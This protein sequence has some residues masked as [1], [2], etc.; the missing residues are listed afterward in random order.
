M[1]GWLA[2]HLFL[3][4]TACLPVPILWA[5]Q[6]SDPFKIESQPANGIKTLFA[7]SPS[8][9]ASPPQGLSSQPN[10]ALHPSN[11]WASSLP[12]SSG[13]VLL[14]PPLHLLCTPTPSHRTPC[15][16]FDVLSSPGT[17]S[18][19]LFGVCLS[20]PLEENPGKLDSTELRP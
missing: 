7:C 2:G 17:V 3:A 12:P 13:Q 9:V 18:G 19:F 20:V 6:Q 11:L 5:W 15:A 14:T 1:L 8:T 4:H 10:K 16:L